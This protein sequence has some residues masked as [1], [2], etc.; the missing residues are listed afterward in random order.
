LL[1]LKENN[2]LHAKEDA[3]ALFIFVAESK[4]TVKKEPSAANTADVNTGASGGSNTDETL[5]AEPWVNSTR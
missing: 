2:E 4:E 3:V 1:R 5:T